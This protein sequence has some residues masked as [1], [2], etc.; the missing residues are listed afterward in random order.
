MNGA[1]A[2]KSIVFTKR[3]AAPTRDRSTTPGQGSLK[4]PLARPAEDIGKLQAILEKNKDQKQRE[5]ERM[6]KRLRQAHDNR[7]RAMN[8]SV[9]SGR[10]THNKSTDRAREA[11]EIDHKMSEEL[12]KKKQA[13]E[14]ALRLIVHESKIANEEAV[15]KSIS[16]LREKKAARAIETRREKSV[17]KEKLNEN[18]LL[19]REKHRKQRL[20]RE[21]ER[22][23]RKHLNQVKKIQHDMDRMGQEADK[24]LKIKREAEGFVNRLHTLE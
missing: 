21:L 23:E 4:L 18:S 8:T 7:D 3:T 6:T 15:S 17:L 22:E 14:D 12:R 9:I 20:M 11:G 10:S 2:G 1:S 24:I 19:A 13:E 16:R 5:E